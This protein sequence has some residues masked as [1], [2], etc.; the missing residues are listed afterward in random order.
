MRLLADC[1]HVLAAQAAAAWRAGLQCHADA[2]TGGAALSALPPQHQQLSP[3]GGMKRTQAQPAT[4]AEEAVPATAAE[5]ADCK[6]QVGPGVHSQ[7]LTA[8]QEAVAF[9]VQVHR[10]LTAPQQPL[11]GPQRTPVAPQAKPIDASGAI[12][13]PQ[14]PAAQHLVPSANCASGQQD[15]QA[16]SA[17]PPAPQSAHERLLSAFLLHLLAA[18]TTELPLQQRLQFH[19]H[20]AYNALSNALEAAPALPSDSGQAAAA[21]RFAAGVVA[22]LPLLGLHTAADLVAL[23]AAEGTACWEVDPEECCILDG[24]QLKV[25]PMAGHKISV[26]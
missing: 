2:A 18:C 16:A 17:R 23:A 21:T 3:L 13:P 14:L 24:N 12:K 10:H 25:S 20:P 11:P 7:C 8:P 1:L 19:Q 6:Q 15:G 22:A 5:E 9:A 26:T 4:A